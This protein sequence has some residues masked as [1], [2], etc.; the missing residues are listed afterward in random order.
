MKFEKDQ[1]LKSLWCEISEE[2]TAW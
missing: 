2:W 1:E